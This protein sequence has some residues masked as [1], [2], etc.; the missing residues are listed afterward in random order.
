M[1]L[2]RKKLLFDNNVRLSIIKKVV[3]LLSSLSYID[4]FFLTKLGYFSIK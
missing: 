1:I 3:S 4:I 2:Y